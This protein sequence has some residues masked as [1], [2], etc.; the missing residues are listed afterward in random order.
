[1]RFLFSKKKK[2]FTIPNFFTVEN[3]KVLV[4]KGCKEAYILPNTILDITCNDSN[5][6][7][8]VTITGRIITEKL[9]IHRGNK[10]SKLKMIID[11]SSTYR[12]SE[13]TVILYDNLICINGKTYKDIHINGIH[14]NLN[15]KD[16][17]LDFYILNRFNVSYTDYERNCSFQSILLEGG[18][19]EVLRKDEYSYTITGRIVN[20]ESRGSHLFITLDCSSEYKGK[21]SSFAISTLNCISNTESKADDTKLILCDHSYND[22]VMHGIIPTSN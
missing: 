8:T 1:M 17:K 6:G 14:I 18:V 4:L 22:G 20:I 21:I 11:T 10:R 9:T 13:T 16:K 12:Y 3:D 7:E 19:I 5:T 2:D 15:L